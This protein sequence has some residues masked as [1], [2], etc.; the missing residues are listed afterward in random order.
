[1]PALPQQILLEGIRA[2]A[3]AS[4][5]VVG[6][7]VLGSFATATADRYSDLDLGLYVTDDALG[8]FDLRVWLERVS[9][10]AALSTNQYGSTVLFRDLIRAEIHFGPLARADDWATLAGQVAYPSL[11]RVV[12]LDRT[13]TLA[14]RIR[15]LIGRP[16]P[17]D[18][19]DGRH[20][21]LALVDSLLVADAC[22]RRGELARAL[23]QLSSA[24]G[25][26][27]RLAR[28]AEGATDEWLAPA[29]HLETA[30]SASAYERYLRTTAS[31]DDARLRDAIA[32]A[33]RWGTELARTVADPPL[34]RD[35]TEALDR[36]LSPPRSGPARS[37]RSNGDPD[38]AAA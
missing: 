20:E 30:L 13:G 15:P 19:K 17:R 36:R 34:D 27:L 18:A 14:A 16:T 6:L 38:G 33:W 10:V 25:S 5:E 12:L 24:H 1:M 26:L 35:T 37:S 2:L 7:V 21:F 31:L 28:L 22:R 23:A 29:R 32:A 11:S 8:T 3:E 9:P 4:L